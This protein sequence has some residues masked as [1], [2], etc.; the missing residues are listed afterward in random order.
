MSSAQAVEIPSPGEMAE[1]VE[2]GLARTDMMVD[3]AVGK[4]QTLRLLVYEPGLQ[5]LAKQGVEAA[6][7]KVALQLLQMLGREPSDFVRPAQRRGGRP[8][9]GQLELFDYAEV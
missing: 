5:R 2:R 6:D 3:Q 8:S 9:K 7:Q 4:P 1:I